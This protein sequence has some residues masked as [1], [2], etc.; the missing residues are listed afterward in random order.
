[1]QS[2]INLRYPVFILVVILLLAC[3]KKEETVNTTDP[4]NLTVNILSVDQATGKVAIQANAQNAVQYDLYLGTNDTP[5][6]TNTS[7]YFEYTCEEEGVYV[8]DVR[9]YGTSGKYIR[10]SSQVTYSLGVDPEPVPLDKGYITPLQYDNYT[11]S[12]HDEFEGSAINSQYWS[13]DL[14][15]G[16]PG[17][18]GWGNNELEYYRRENAWVAND[19]LTIEARDENYS[20]RSYTSAKLKTAGKK[21]VQYGRID[22]RALLPVGQGL[23]PALWMLG[24]NIGSVGWPSSGEIDIMEMIG[25]NNRENQVHGTIHWNAGGHVSSGNPYTLSSG[26]FA[27]EYHVFTL[28]WDETYL[29]WYVNNQLFNTINIAEAGYEAFHQPFWF[30]FN[31]AVGGSWPGNPNSTTVFPQQMKVDYIRVFQKNSD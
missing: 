18:C 23:W 21:S 16:C 1:M 3:T 24:D 14:G 29:R 6:S 10:K 27:T 31:V 22:I 17:N 28:I 11:L 9:A 4:V 5:L 8:F 13:F 12:W 26:T 2:V 19:V 15:D 7:G 20:N 25:G 30:I